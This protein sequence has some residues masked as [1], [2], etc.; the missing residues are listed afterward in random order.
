MRRPMKT[1]ISRN[2]N[3]YVLSPFGNIDGLGN[4][5]AFGEF[6]VVSPGRGSFQNSWTNDDWTSANRKWSDH[7]KYWFKLN[8]EPLD[9]GILDR[10]R[11]KGDKLNTQAKAGDVAAG[12]L[13]LSLIDP[14]YALI[15][16]ADA[17]T[18]QFD[19]LGNAS[20]AT[21]R[22]RFNIFNSLNAA[23]TKLAN[24]T[25]PA[26]TPPAD[27]GAGITG[28]APGQTAANVYV[29]Q[30]QQ[31]AAAAAAAKAANEAA[32][33]AKAAADAQAAA[34]LNPGLVKTSQSA[35]SAA[36]TGPSNMLL[37][38]G[39]GLVALLGVGFVLSR[40]KAS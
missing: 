2:L 27:A 28:V 8:Y 18:S 9:E 6:L 12:G 35:L 3:G 16:R 23:I 36:Q 31:A 29:F 32:A 26:F 10:A 5:A 24:V 25:I 37:F 14:I 1:R 19:N 30:A 38:G 11:E 34:K 20:D 22:D 7:I 4:F 13:L 21:H 39:I 17:N 40:K 15:K 33:T